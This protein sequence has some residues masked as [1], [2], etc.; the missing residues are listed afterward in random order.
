MSDLLTVSCGL[1][2]GLILEV[3]E[4]LN[5]RYKMSLCNE[6]FL[7]S[8]P[9]LLKPRPATWLGWEVAGVAPSTTSSPPG[10][11]DSPTTS[12]SASSA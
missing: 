8:S 7:V 4:V 10:W 9:N 1:L 5:L 2:G 6:R 12:L 3:G 11:S